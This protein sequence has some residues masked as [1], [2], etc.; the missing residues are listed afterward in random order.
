MAE[1]VGFGDQSVRCQALADLMENGPDLGAVL[2][3]QS[4]LAAQTDGG[5]A[6]STS[7]TQRESIRS[8]AGVLD[9]RRT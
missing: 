6:V 1:Q 7:M 9:T 8:V 3:G 5:A 2:F 4:G